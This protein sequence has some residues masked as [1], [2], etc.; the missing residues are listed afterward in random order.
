VGD[1]RP[2]YFAGGKSRRHRVVRCSRRAHGIL[3]YRRVDV[4]MGWGSGQ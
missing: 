4:G 1:A 2:F 3:Y